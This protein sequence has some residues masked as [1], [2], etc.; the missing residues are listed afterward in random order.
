MPASTTSPN[1]DPNITVNMYLDT[2]PVEDEAF[3]VSL[4]GTFTVGTGFTERVLTFETNADAQASAKLSTAAKAACAAAFAQTGV[5]QV[6]VGRLNDVT[7][8]VW[9]VTVSA[10]QDG[11]YTVTPTLNG[12]AL[13]PYAFTRASGATTSQIVDGLLALMNADTALT[14]LVTLVDGGAS[15]TITTK[16]EDTTLTVT[17]NHS[18]T[19][20]NITAAQTTAAVTVAD[21]LDAIAAA[22]PVW[23]GLCITSRTT[24]HI[25]AAA[26]WIESDASR[27]FLAQ[28]N[29]ADIYDPE[30]DTD[31]L[32]DLQA[33]DYERTAFLWY[34]TDA[35]FPDFAWMAERLHWDL[36]EQ[37]PSWNDVTLSGIVA[38]TLPSTTAKNAVFTK[39]GNVYLPQ[40]GTN[41]TDPGKMVNGQWIDAQVVGD[42]LRSRSADAI[43]TIKTATAARGQR[44]PYTKAGFE[45]LVAGARAVFRQAERIGHLVPGSTVFTVPELSAISNTDRQ[46]RRFTFS[47]TAT[48]AGGIR[49]V[50]FNGY[51]TA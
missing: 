45:T 12:T 26:A 16:N 29:D 30:D 48:L 22:D 42:W 44:I 43:A 47:A 17:D 39:G 19:P 7:Y 14:D 8:E 23:Y 10:A 37:S 40:Y 36:D 11:I 4:I 6:K 21:A 9:T 28:S 31:L 51:L 49:T 2:P 1:L 20:S 38:S 41:V 24:N 35:A 27:I 18:V 32:S 3:G 13:G 34:Q 46:N 33:R 50:T 25:K 15:F 5:A